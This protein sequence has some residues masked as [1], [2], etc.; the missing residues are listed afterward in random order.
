MFV[1]K[2][3]T[4]LKNI[5]NGQN[6]IILNKT[7]LS[8]FLKKNKSNDIEFLLQLF[9]KGILQGEYGISLVSEKSTIFYILREYDNC[10]H[11]ICYDPMEL[12]ETGQNSATR[13]LVSKRF[14]NGWMYR[15]NRVVEDERKWPYKN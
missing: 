15:I 3:I 5:S 9:K 8:A 10:V 13:T 1:K 4:I 2:N 11:I 7:N 14:K 6:G 12:Y